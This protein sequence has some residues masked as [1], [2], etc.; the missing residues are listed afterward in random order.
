MNKILANV[1]RFTTTDQAATM[2]EYGL[3]LLLV[4]LVCVSVVSY[5]GSNEVIP[6]FRLSGL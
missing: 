2:I 3:V 5:I 4:A 1:R 6:L